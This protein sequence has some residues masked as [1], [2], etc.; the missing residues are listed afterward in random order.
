MRQVEGFEGSCASPLNS[1]LGNTPSIFSICRRLHVPDRG[2]VEFP[3]DNVAKRSL[4][5]LRFRAKRF[6]HGPFF[7]TRKL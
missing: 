4:V 2:F 6:L 1:Y 3:D 7:N 5:T